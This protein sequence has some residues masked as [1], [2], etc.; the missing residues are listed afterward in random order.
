MKALRLILAIVLMFVAAPQVWAQKVHVKGYVK[1]DGTYVAPH[2][3]KA[4]KS[5]GGTTASSTGS[6]K[7]GSDHTPA[8]TTSRPA[9]SSNSSHKSTSTT[10]IQRSERPRAPSS[11]G[12]PDTRTGA[13]ATSSTTSSRSPAA[14]PTRR[15]TCSG[16]RSAPR[17]PRTSGSGTGAGGSEAAEPRRR[18]HRSHTVLK[19]EEGACNENDRC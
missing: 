2:E 1:K 11:C 14:E 16:R 5:Q 18:V 3:R 6:T 15:A 7:S 4:P 17:R 13:L 8:S 9:T 12:A 10:M 19:A